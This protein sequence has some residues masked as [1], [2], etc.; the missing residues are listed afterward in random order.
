MLTTVGSRIL[1]ATGV[2][3]KSKGIDCKSS[4]SPQRKGPLVQGRA[5]EVSNGYDS[6][7][8]EAT[9]STANPQSN[10]FSPS[11]S[12]SLGQATVQLAACI[13]DPDIYTLEDGLNVTAHSMGPSSEQDANLL[14]SFR[15]VLVDEGNRVH[16]D[17]LEISATNSDPA[18]PPAYFSKCPWVFCQLS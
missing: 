4:G 2:Y 17:Y 18:L 10:A 3:C 12:Q 9:L 7:Q 1:T 5:F 14:Q 13:S 16:N 6:A 15:T 11:T 8:P